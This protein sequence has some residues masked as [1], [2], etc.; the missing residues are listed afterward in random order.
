MVKFQGT[1]EKHRLPTVALDV[2]WT[3]RL[4]EHKITQIQLRKKSGTDELFK[5]PEGRPVEIQTLTKQETQFLID[6]VFEALLVLDNKKGKSETQETEESKEEPALSLHSGK[7]IPHQTGDRRIRFSSASMSR[8]HATSELIAALLTSMS[9]ARHAQEKR[10]EE[11]REKTIERKQRML[12]EDL[13]KHDIIASN[14]QH[15]ALSHDTTFPE[16]LQ[17]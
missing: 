1:D 8:E 12:Q 16:R 4:S 7:T 9:E 5:P 11:K 2:E 15:D 14:I 17:H 13:L 3:L 10:E 6:F